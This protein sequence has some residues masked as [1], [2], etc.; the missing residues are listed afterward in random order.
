MVGGYI[1]RYLP[2]VRDTPERVRDTPE[3][4]RDTPERRKM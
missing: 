3:R 1:H 4:V 2:R